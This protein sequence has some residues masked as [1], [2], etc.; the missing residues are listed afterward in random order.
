VDS[1]P[2]P[3]S[4][5]ERDAYEAMRDALEKTIRQQPGTSAA[6]MA[7]ESLERVIAA[8]GAGGN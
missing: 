3:R 6:E 7:R 2:P 1:L 4:D 5:A 8:L